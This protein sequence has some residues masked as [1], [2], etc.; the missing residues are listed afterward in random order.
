MRSGSGNAGRQLAKHGFGDGAGLRQ[1]HMNVRP[2]LEEDLITERP[3]TVCDSVC[4]MLS[5]TV[6]M[7]RSKGETMRSSIC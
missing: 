5:T 2:G 7:K 1:R 4:S 3:P 6:V